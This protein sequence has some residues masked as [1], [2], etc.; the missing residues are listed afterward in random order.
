MGTTVEIS[1]FQRSCLFS[2]VQ[3]NA[4]LEG[5]HKKALYSPNEQ[6]LQCLESILGKQVEMHKIVLIFQGHS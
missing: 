4:V 3:R 6:Q 5:S 2:K 1:F